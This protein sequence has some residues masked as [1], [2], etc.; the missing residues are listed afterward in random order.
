MTSQESEWFISLSESPERMDFWLE[1]GW[2]HFGVYFFRHQTNLMNDEI[3]HVEPLR[4]KVENFELSKSQRRLYSVNSDLKIL[5]REAAVTEEKENLFLQHAERFSDNR[6]DSLFD[7]LSEQ[8]ATVPCETKE[9]CLFK[10]EKLVAVSFFDVGKTSISSL[11][12]MFDPD[13]SKRSLG[14]YT[15]LL[16]IELSQK[17]RKTYY[18]P[19]YSYREPSIYDYKKR[20]SAL[21]YLDWKTGWKPKP[22]S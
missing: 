21:E 4:I 20:F 19:G 12:A 22:K 13:E 14:I 16:E 3:F 11:Y 5:V 15:M 18:Y 2:R 6:P 10:N 1:N 9:I 8:P 17:L 7:F